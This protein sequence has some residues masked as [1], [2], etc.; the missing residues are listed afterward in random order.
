MRRTKYYDDWELSEET[1]DIDDRTFKELKK[2]RI[3]KY[4]DIYF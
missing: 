2:R 3:N 4:G 1:I